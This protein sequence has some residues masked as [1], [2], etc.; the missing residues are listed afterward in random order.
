M[1]ARIDSRILRLERAL[2]ARQIVCSRCRDWQPEVVM[3]GDS[4]PPA[5]CTGCGRERPADLWV[6]RF[7]AREDGPQ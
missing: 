2:P 6:V 3:E 7:V 4:E 5:R 1:P